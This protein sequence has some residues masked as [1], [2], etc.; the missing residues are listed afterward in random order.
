MKL[1]I[2]PFDQNVFLKKKAKI[3]FKVANGLI[4]QYIIGLFQSRADSLPNTSLRSVSNENFT[5]PKPKCSLYKK[6]LS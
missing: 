1:N 3:M 2:L 4:Q 5:F 6:N